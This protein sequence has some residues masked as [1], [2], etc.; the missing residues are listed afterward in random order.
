MSGSYEL[1]GSD[2]RS[3]GTSGPM[4]TFAPAIPEPETWLL[5]AFGLGVLAWVRR[6]TVDPRSARSSTARLSAPSRQSRQEKRPARVGQRFRPR[7]RP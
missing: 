2:F 6:R 4:T 7:Q 5:M 3:R 1:S